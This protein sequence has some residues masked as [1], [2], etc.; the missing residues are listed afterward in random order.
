MSMMNT[1]N[2]DCFIERHARLF[3]KNS[4]LGNMPPPDRETFLRLAQRAEYKRGNIIFQEGEIADKLY[5]VVS[6]KVKISRFTSDGR[7]AVLHLFGPGEPIGEAAALQNGNFPARAET[8]EDSV[9]L[10]WPRSILLEFIRD[11]PSFA[12]NLMGALA[13]R[14]KNFADKIETLALHDTPQRLAAYLLHQS[15]Q[16]GG[17]DSFDLDV[18]KGLLAAVLG[19]ARETLS[20]CI[21]RFTKENIIALDG[22]KVTILNRPSLEDLANGLAEL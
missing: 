9:I 7:E 14:L 22:R 3:S 17:G 1:E 13:M 21:S 12:M 18:N 8:L 11:N 10:L 15:E 2:K 6:G 20:R 16:S 19:T 4:L 5:V